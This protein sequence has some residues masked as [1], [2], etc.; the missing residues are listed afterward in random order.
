MPETADPTERPVKI[1]AHRG[2]SAY[3][4]ENTMAAFRMAWHMGADG[5][6]LDCHLSSDGIPVVIHDPT[7]LRTAGI[8]RP[9]AACSAAELQNTDVGAWKGAEFTGETVPRLSD[10][11]CGT[12]PGRTVFIEMKAPAHP[13]LPAAV[14]AVV[15]DFP[16]LADSIHAISFDPQLLHAWHSA[17]PNGRSL[18]LLNDKSPLP[19]SEPPSPWHGYGVSRRLKLPKSLLQALHEN[20][21]TLSV[22]TVNRKSTARSYRQLGFH[23]LTSDYPDLAACR[24]LPE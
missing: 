4:P 15:E 2:A 18:L 6:E 5:I 9:V 1:I 22:W 21:A 10:V 3:A 17:H 16:E 7:L 8:N 24:A 14:A 11:L 12:P 20:Q 23:Y 19:G 13:D